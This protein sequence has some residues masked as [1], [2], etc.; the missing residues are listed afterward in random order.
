MSDVFSA[1]FRSEV[2]RRVRR[3]GT[4]EETLLYR[5]LRE[6]GERPRRNVSRLPGKPDLVFG[7]CQLAVFVDGDFWHGRAWFRD[8]AAPTTNRRFWIE[9]FE[10]NR[11]RDRRV[12]RK[13]RA[14]GWR[15]S[16]LWGTDVRRDPSKAA[17]RVLK[18]LVRLR[19]L[20]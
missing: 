2:M 7:D 16:R 3:T 15:V 11:R 8:G 19:E 10:T 5:A 13:L 12:D 18:R 17:A 20:E 14:L 1:E 6:I 4:H 9:R